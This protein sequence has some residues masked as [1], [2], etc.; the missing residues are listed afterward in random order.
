MSELASTQIP[1]PRDEQAFERCNE[2]LWRC[3]LED[4]TVKLYGRRGQRQHGVD[5]TGIRHDK[6]G[7]IVGVQCKLK[8]DGKLTNAEVRA[9]VTK[10]LTFTPPLSE[11]IIV[12]TAPD[13]RNLDR[14]A[15]ELSMSA[16]EGREIDIKVRI[17]GW[18]TLEREIHR[19][20]RA[21]EAFDPLHTPQSEWM[22]DKIDV[23]PRDT[24]DK[25]DA[26]LA[27][28]LDSIVN[29][30]RSPHTIDLE[31]GAVAVHSE[32]ERQIND[33]VELMAANPSGAL[34]M[35][36][37]LER[38][39]ANDVPD[40]IRFRVVTNI[41]VCQLKTGEIDIAAQGFVDVWKLAPDDPKAASNKAFGLLV[42]ED[43]TALSAFA[44]EEL[45]KH[46]DNAALAGCYIRGLVMDGTVADPLSKVPEIVRCTAE[47]AEARV[48]WLMNRDASGAWWEPAIAAHAAHP[49]DNGLREIC[50]GALLDR[51]LG[52]GAFDCPSY[53]FRPAQKSWCFRRSS[54]WLRWS[55]E[56]RPVDDE[57]R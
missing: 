3:I 6:P 29:A 28:R 44:E 43:W 21:R 7:K 18:G 39:L 50:A 23:L 17:F 56:G 27:P 14:L 42:Q 30:M 35:L 54:D 52:G 10:A 36:R 55:A 11:Y 24:A 8:G 45:P 26:L 57:A 40:R 2:V 12:T 38:R 49:D 19:F 16:S 5:L 34:A 4:E 46:P 41:A 13:D 31:S 51:A 1:K 9:E 20:L 47:V 53:K 32:Q 48:L 15:H 22:K 33:C 25:V 37:R